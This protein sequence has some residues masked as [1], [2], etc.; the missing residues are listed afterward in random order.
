MAGMQQVITAVREHNSTPSSLR[1]GHPAQQFFL[2]DNF[3]QQVPSARFP[4]VTSRPLF[5]HAPIPSTARDRF[6]NGP[7]SEAL[8][9]NSETGLPKQAEWS[10]PA[11]KGAHRV[12]AGLADA[13]LWS[14]NGRANLVCT[15]I[16][17]E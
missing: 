7:A 4:R 11:T 2:T 15:R 5:Y 3:S 8:I 17:S 12:C 1:F 16:P 13:I 9:R 10:F 14:L 6:A